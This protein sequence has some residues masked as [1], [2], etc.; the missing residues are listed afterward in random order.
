MIWEKFDLLQKIENIND[1]KA[2]LKDSFIFNAAIL[3]N[4][5]FEVPYN[6]FDYIHKSS[7]MD[8]LGK[9]SNKENI[10]DIVSIVCDED[11]DWGEQRNE[12]LTGKFYYKF[13]LKSEYI[14]EVES[15]LN[16]IKERYEKR[17]QKIEEFLKEEELK[18]NE[19]EKQFS[20]LTVH[21]DIM[22]GK[23]VDG[24]LDISLK[25]NKTSEIVRIVERNVFDFG[26]YAYPKRLEGTRDIFDV[27][28][29]T[30]VEIKACNW[31]S[32]FSK[33]STDIRM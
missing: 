2:A 4:S 26:H 32:E 9:L 6:Y 20:I 25:H 19:R 5:F 27:N 17:I 31:A 3:D 15:F 1:Y 10:W 33:M 24:Y 28:L 30:E 23:D 14:P 13:T 16:D 21:E 12:N 7:I 18:K 22:P 11:K 29:W 8:L